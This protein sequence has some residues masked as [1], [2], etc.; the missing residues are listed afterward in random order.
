MV[1]PPVSAWLTALREADAVLTDSFHGCVFALLFGR[2]F[3]T[4]GNAVRGQARFSSLL[5]LFGL[6]CRMMGGADA[7]AVANRMSEPIDWRSVNEILCRE[8]ER[9]VDF[10]RQ[11]LIEP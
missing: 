5:S 6:E 3:V 8:R 1:H 9:S 7:A 11:T 4:L 2:P 10:L